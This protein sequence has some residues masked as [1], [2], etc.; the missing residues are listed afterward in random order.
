MLGKRKL[1]TY[2]RHATRHDLQQ[3]VGH[4]SLAAAPPR[5][6]RGRVEAEREERSSHDLPS[7]LYEKCNNYLRAPRKRLRKISCR[8]II[9]MA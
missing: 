5:E 6:G 9:I 8:S 7:L 1:G 3:L 2:L 4:E